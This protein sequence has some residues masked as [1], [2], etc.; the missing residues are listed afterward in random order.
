[1][2]DNS[3]FVQSPMANQCNDMH[4]S[5]VVKVP[6][7]A[8]FVVF[9]YTKFDAEL[10]SKSLKGYESVFYMMSFAKLKVRSV[11]MF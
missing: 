4:P 2:S 1:M 6:S 9:N 7:G 10:Q 8:S 5:T 11:S 3:V